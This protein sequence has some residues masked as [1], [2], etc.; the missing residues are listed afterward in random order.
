MPNGTIPN[1]MPLFRS[2]FTALC[3]RCHAAKPS[4]A[5]NIQR[6]GKPLPWCKTCHRDH[7]AKNRDVIA[8]KSLALR[9]NTAKGWAKYLLCSVKARSRKTR[10]PPPNLT[11][12]NLARMRKTSLTCPYYP[13]IAL[14][15][16]TGIGCPTTATLNRIRPP[17]GYVHGNCVLISNRANRQK[18]DMSLAEM[19]NIIAVTERLLGAF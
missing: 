19:R 8:A 13:E 9:Q 7:Y 15:Y 1:F 2:A 4:D 5:F 16:F 12:D 18:Q 3:T 14:T 10:L 6:N 11:W 17:L